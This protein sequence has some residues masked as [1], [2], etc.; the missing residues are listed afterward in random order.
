MNPGKI[1]EALLSNQVMLP[2]SINIYLKNNWLMAKQPLAYEIE[3]WYYK[4]WV[5]NVYMLRT[6]WH[7]TR[8]GCVF[9]KCP[10]NELN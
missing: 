5:S 1:S 4:V 8:G 3:P 7:H 6:V 9:N 2:N 10:H